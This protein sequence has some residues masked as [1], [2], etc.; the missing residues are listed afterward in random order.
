MTDEVDPPP[1]FPLY[2]R[3][4]AVAHVLSL[5][6]G[7]I[8]FFVLAGIGCFLY[9]RQGRVDEN[10]LALLAMGVACPGACALYRRW[11]VSWGR[12]NWPDGK[13]Q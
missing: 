7:P 9:V 5:A 1:Q 6:V 3:V 4:L 2:V 11:F 8:G 13:Y 12:M 10:V